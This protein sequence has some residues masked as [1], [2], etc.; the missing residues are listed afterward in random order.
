M[1][2]YVYLHGQEWGDLHLWH[3]AAFKRPLLLLLLLRLLLLLL[4]G[5]SLHLTGLHQHLLPH[6]LLLLLLHLLGG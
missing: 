3:R 6:G 5:L 2:F 4:Y 1:R